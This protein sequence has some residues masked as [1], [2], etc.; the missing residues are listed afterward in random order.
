[1]SHIVEAKTQIENPD[2]TLL[3]QSVEIVASQ[4]AGGEVR[5]HYLSYEGQQRQADLAIATT[6]MHRG[7]AI[8]VKGGRLTFV[9]D[10]WGYGYHYQQI[11]QQILQTY[12]SLATVQA[13]Q[14]LGYQVNTEDGEAGQVV[15][16]GVTYA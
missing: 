12:V 15:I 11:Q 3:R 2:Q 6:T 7:M 5:N 9:G 13:L 10:S 16:S 1:M 4:H 8:Q 14:A